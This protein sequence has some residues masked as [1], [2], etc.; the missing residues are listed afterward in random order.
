MEDPSSLIT[1]AKLLAVIVLVLANG[2]FVAAEFSLV[3]MRRSR[4]EQ[5]V[6]DGHPLASSVQRAV[7]H[8]DAYL[9]AT[10]LGITMASIGLGWIGEPALAGLIEPILHFLPGD[11]SL[12]GSHTVAVAVAF[13]IITALHIVLG[14]LAPKS[15]A[16]QRTEGTA[17][18]LGRPLELFLVVF[19]PAI[20]FLN[21]LGNLVLRL[22]GL[23]PAGSEELVHSIEELKLLIAASREAGVLGQEAEEIV[24]RAFELDDFAAVQVMVPRVE[25]ISVPVDAA[26]DEVLAVGAEHHHTRLPVYGKDADEIVG[27]VHLMDVVRA[28]QTGYR[29]DLR[30]LTRPAL[31]VP[32]MITADKLLGRMRAE[33]AQMA[34]L[35]DEYGGT[36]GL[37]TI[38]DL[39]ERLV[40]PLLD[41]QEVAQ[42]CIEITSDGDAL[43]GGLALVHDINDRFGLHIEDGEEFHTVGGFVQ[44]RLGRL[45]VPG[46]EVGVDGYVFRVESLDGRRI[47]RLRLVKAPLTTGANSKSRD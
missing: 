41:V 35:V 28:C 20:Y 32:E 30:Q 12:I 21:G 36:A 6:A 13:G 16:L 7:Q 34:I 37:V 1:A 15:L 47:D 31:T 26:L 25:M 10:Q 5:L 44:A 17:L 2:F 46:D 39:V 29:N 19:R 8:L 38:H 42:D 18:A 40:G 45:P 33:R 22:F 27:I 24:E 11:W 14:E 9:A 23:R 4:V 43:V 3:A